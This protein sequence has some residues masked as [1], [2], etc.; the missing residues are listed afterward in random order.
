[1]PAY[2]F[3]GLTLASDFPFPEL[4][5]HPARRPALR[6]ALGERQARDSRRTWLH[7]WRFPDGRVWM[8]LSRD[9][10]SSIVQF[11]GLGEFRISGRHVTCHPRTGTPLRTIRH[12]LLDQVL[13]ATLASDRRMVVHASA[14]EIDGRAVGFVGPSGAGKSTIA[15]AM[16]RRGASAL[17]DDALVIDVVRSRA[18]AVPTYPGFRLWPASRAVIGNWPEVRRARVSHYSRK[19]RWSGPAVRFAER[20][21]KLGALYLV[22]RGK[23]P[24]FTPLTGRDS[25]MALI[26]FSMLLDATNASAMKNGFH[27]AAAIVESVKVERLVMP[28]G[29]EIASRSRGRVRL[30]P[31]ATSF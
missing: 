28:N 10:A 7:R 31:D 13:P 16:V 29:G 25:I 21:L 5:S 11:P 2:R 6:I 8:R 12:L 1:V 14:V 17:T 26:R 20:P 19:Q 24:R 15:A 4:P 27:L 22:R 9:G 18:I 3:A 30:K 23:H